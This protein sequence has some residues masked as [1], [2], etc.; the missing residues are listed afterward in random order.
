[1]ADEPH[2]LLLSK[3]QGH[4]DTATKSGLHALHY[5]GG[6]QIKHA[7]TLYS[8]AL[9]EVEA[10]KTLLNSAESVE[11][12]EAAPQH[13][14]NTRTDLLLKLDQ[15]QEHCMMRLDALTKDGDDAAPLEDQETIPAEDE[16]AE[17]IY[18]MQ[19]VQLF[20]VTPAGSEVVQLTNDAELLLLKVQDQRFLQCKE[21]LYPLI[22]DLPCLRIQPRFYIFSGGNET[23]HD[24]DDTAMGVLLPPTMAAVDVK[25][26]EELL[27]EYTTLCKSQPDEEEEEVLEIVTAGVLAEQAGPV[28][29]TEV[30]PATSWDARVS[31]WLLSG[32]TVVAE[33]LKGVAEIGGSF[34][35]SGGESL[36]S[37]LTRADG[38]VH[39]DPRVQA[40]VEIA[41]EASHATYR[42]TAYTVDQVLEL[43]GRAAKTVAP[44]VSRALGNPKGGNGLSRKVAHVAKSGGVGLLTVV[45]GLEEA[46]RVLVTELASESTAT[47]RHRYGDD[48]AQVARSSMDVVG[49]TAGIYTSL[50][51][52]RTK[53]VAKFA[54]KRTAV[55]VLDEHKRFLEAEANC[56]D[57]NDDMMAV[58]GGVHPSATQKPSLQALLPP[59]P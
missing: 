45:A 28:E 24:E 32:A 30:T 23:Q 25:A 34:I 12:F 50:R 1:M 8:R 19:G 13:A 55:E 57:E 6:G 56:D 20:L 58:D 27:D 39:V 11:L 17:L 59:P 7:T 26:F 38:N 51:R 9:R 41:K 2:A 21:W 52:V 37:R 4:L 47:V 10:G 5:D 31:S 42:V 16:A 22:D 54:V 49:N 43:A 29:P 36:R 53:A 44:M 14:Q 48:A 15:T 3:A 35:R 46:G 18:S 40:S 33:S